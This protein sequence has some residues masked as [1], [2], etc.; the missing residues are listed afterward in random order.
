MVPQVVVGF[1]GEFPYDAS[2]GTAQ[3][4][5]SP[6]AMRSGRLQDRAF[7]NILFHAENMSASLA[8]E[9][10]EVKE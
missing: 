7:T 6:S 4:P 1:S 9:C 5:G 2:S 8:P 10:N 3:L